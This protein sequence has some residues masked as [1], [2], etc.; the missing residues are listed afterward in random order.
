MMIRSI[1]PSAERM[2][3]TTMACALACMA[4]S[5]IVGAIGALSYV[6]VIGPAMA[7]RGLSLV[8]LRPLHT[9]FASAW[10]YLGCVAGM[11]AFLAHAF[12]APSRRDRLRFRIHMVCWGVAGAG[13]LITLLFGWGSG[14]E[15]LGFHPA[16]SVLII[17]GWL[18][19]LW[20]F[21]RRV[22]PGFWSRPVYVYMWTT[23]ALYFVYTFVEGHAYLLPSVAGHPVA[24][25][26]I[27]WKSCGS[28]V[29][30]FNQMVYGTL[31]FVGERMTNDRRAGQ[32]RAAF[33]LFGIGLLNSFTNSAHHTY[34]LP[35][36]ALIK[37]IAFVVSMLELIILWSLLADIVRKVGTRRPHYRQFSASTHLFALS[38]HWNA[39]LLP[40]ALLISIP[41]LNALIHG[42]HVVMAHAM[43]SELAID[44][45]ILLGA[46]AWLFARS[47]PKR[48]AVRD[49]INGPRVRHYIGWLN[50][51]LMVLIASLLIRG[52]GVGVTRYLGHPE[53]EWLGVFPAVFVISGVAVG[54]SLL[55]LILCWLPLLRE[56]LRHR[57]FRDDPRWTDSTSPF[58]EKRRRYR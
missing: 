14:R 4:I 12:G 33:T 18:C 9:T 34:H 3:L 29:A 49:V 54:Y 6:P 8:Q 5:I 39:F 21:L 36:D 52:L 48:E 57:L 42:T 46:F 50:R 37:W 30:S 13:A 28:L 25:L 15:Y 32:S 56:P 47:F 58:L 38:K 19:F 10:I 17:V 43:G 11:Y 2:V 55:N 31:L 35:Q 1:V 23:G 24:D 40:V 16:F 26:Q 44:S 41:P 27:Q 45:Y 7:G 20:T 22:L 53:P 51:T